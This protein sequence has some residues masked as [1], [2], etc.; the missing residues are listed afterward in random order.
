MKK[1]IKTLIAAAIICSSLFSSTA[2][3]AQLSFGARA[4]ANFATEPVPGLYHV[5]LARPNAGLFAQYNFHS[6]LGV[7]V[8]LTYSG[9]GANYRD[10]ATGITYQVRHAFLN[11]PVWAQ[12]KFH[13]GGYIEAGPQFGVLLSAKE[14]ENNSGLTDSKQY[15]KGTDFGAGIGFGYEVPKGAVKGFG[16]NV[17]YIRGLT[18]INKESIQGDDI[19]TRVL[20]IGLTYRIST[21]G[22]H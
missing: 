18:N 16:L 22:A 20:A 9:E 10:D 6:P 12:Y 3:H 5:F 15:Y 13:F 11:I 2:L 14:G 8:G 1:Q 21:G 4:G 17:R 19:K 7:Q